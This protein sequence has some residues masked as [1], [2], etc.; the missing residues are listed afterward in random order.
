M[1]PE[2]FAGRNSCHVGRTTK[3]FG[4]RSIGPGSPGEIVLL[5][6]WNGRKNLLDLGRRI[7]SKAS[8]FDHRRHSPC[9]DRVWLRR[10]QR[11]PERN[12]WTPL[13]VCA[14]AITRSIE[15]FGQGLGTTV[16]LAAVIGTVTPSKNMLFP[17]TMGQ[18]PFD[19][20]RQ[21]SFE[22]GLRNPTELFSELAGIHRVTAVV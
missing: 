19:S 16:V 15:N 10:L 22:T 4:R 6:I 20:P 12:F 8:S 17:I 2:G 9:S 5:A 13:R 18:I 14:F 3:K 1:R 7:P 11:R 21:T